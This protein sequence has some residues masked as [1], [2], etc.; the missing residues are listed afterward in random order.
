MNDA[1]PTYLTSA[2][3]TGFDPADGCSGQQLTIR[4][5]G[6]GTG[7]GYTIAFTDE[8]KRVHTAKGSDIVSWS[9]SSIVVTIPAGART[10]AV[11]ILSVPSAPRGASDAFVE[12]SLACFGPTVVARMQSRIKSLWP[13]AKAPAAQPDGANIFRGGLP[14]IELLDVSPKQLVPGQQITIRWRVSG[15]GVVRIAVRALGSAS[16]ELPDVNG[17]LSP[18]GGEVTLPVPGTRSWTAQYVLQATNHCGTEERSVDVTMLVR[19]G[20]ALGGG[21]TRGDFQVGALLY[22]YD[23]I[24]FRPDAIAATS[25][26][27]INALDLAMG[28]DHSPTTVSAA[29]RLAGIWLTRMRT[30]SDMWRDEPWMTELRKVA[31][32]IAESLGRDWVF[33]SPYAAGQLG[34]IRD[35][36]LP[37]MTGGLFNLNPL[38]S[39]INQLV[40]PQR[41]ADSGIAL[42]LL[43]V[44]LETGEIIMVNEK[45]FVLS[46]TAPVQSESPRPDTD[47]RDGAIASASMPGVFP[48]VRLGDHM[49]VDG[50]IR[51]VV[52]VV[53]AVRELGCSKIYAIR[54]SAPVAFQRT[55]PARTAM[56]V[57]PRSL[58][59]I[60]FD[61]IAD[62]DIDPPN[63]WGNGIEVTSIEATVNLHDPIVVE[64]ALIRIGMDY[65]WMRAAD[66]ISVPSQSRQHAFDLS[67]RITLLRGQN[68]RHMHAVA[69]ARWDD[70]HRSFDWAVAVGQATKHTS[71][72]M[73]SDLTAVEP[74]RRNCREIYS[75]LQQR[76]SIGASVPSEAENWY[77]KW[78]YNKFPSQP[79]PVTS[80][81][82]ASLRKPWLPVSPWDAIRSGQNSVPA[83][84]PP[85]ALP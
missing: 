63:G 36:T 69:G 35:Q 60:V 39:L 48:P 76:L 21:G 1:T 67:D 2:A 7:T 74:L 80:R 6:F 9:D 16:N 25:V 68:C 55:N 43:S 38:R 62:N 83:A 77:Q 40:S 52:P 50:G 46:N 32:N 47:V 27:S 8:H 12:S 3:I 17:T 70:P 84:S 19:S 79:P 24:G 81:P 61:E 34:W 85:P 33:A 71:T 44:S 29:R 18:T 30:E 41:V 26:G 53:T 49:C 22:L 5:K 37:K 4:G 54:V 66:V 23:E 15:A 13:G 58:F 10:G 42:R 59:D 78:E 75:L 45:G 14:V 31:G 73:L 57:L 11:G 72:S 64:P 82:S 28:D 51:H 65:G 20:I 56:D